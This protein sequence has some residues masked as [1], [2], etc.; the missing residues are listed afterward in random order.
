MNW[1]IV[2]PNIIYPIR[3]CP[4]E[5]RFNPVCG[6]N[7]ITYFNR[8]LLDCNNDIY[9]NQYPPVLA[10]NEGECRND[11]CICQDVSLPVCT[12]DGQTYPNECELNCENINRMNHKVPILYLAFRAACN[13]YACPCT[14]IAA[15]VCGTDNILYRNKCVLDCARKNA[16]E[17]KLPPIEF[18]NY[19]ACLDQCSCPETKDPI[20]GSDGKIYDNYC[21]IDCENRRLKSSKRQLIYTVDKSYCKVCTCDTLYNPVCGSDGRTYSSSCELTCEAKR[22]NNASLYI[23]G[24]G[25]CPNSYCTDEYY[26]VC[27]TNHVTYTNEC[28]LRYQNEG[29][30]ASNYV[31]IFHYGACQQYECDCSYCPIDYQPVC[32]NDQH[33][34]WNSCWLNCNSECYKRN[35][36]TTVTL[37]KEGACSM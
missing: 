15:P 33:V 37:S 14:D 34:Y 35:R 3:A 1:K 12:L 27:G 24:E 10:Q 20:C 6:S 8:C 11:E 26:P 4:C 9:R 19:G 36:Q 7:N 30:S 23:V 28:K 13:G 25:P 31:G 29:V 22:Q 2:K 5:Y 18:K 16:N 17:K 32:G 21:K